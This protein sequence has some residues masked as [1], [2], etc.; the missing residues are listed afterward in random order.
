MLYFRF[1]IHSILFFGPKFCSIPG[2]LCSEFLQLSPATE[3]LNSKVQFYFL[4][5]SFLEL[6][7]HQLDLSILNP[8]YC[9]F[10][11]QIFPSSIQYIVHSP[12]RS[13]H[14]QSNSIVEKFHRQ[15]KVSL[16]ARL[17]GTDWY[18]NLFPEKIPQFP[19]LKLCLVP[20]GTSWSIPGQSS[21]PCRRISLTSS[22]S[23]QKLSCFSASSKV[24]C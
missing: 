14:P 13:F 18:A 5:A 7:I 6:Y 4:C 21:A 24:F 10:T 9:T 22:A 16:Q 23:S 3:K 15:L 11:N 17:A 12:T 2:S 20:H 19:P 8:I 1:N